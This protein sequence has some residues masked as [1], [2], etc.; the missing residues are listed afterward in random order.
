MGKEG[1]DQFC[2]NLPLF[3]IV[4]VSRPQMVLGIWAHVSN[5]GVVYIKGQCLFWVKCVG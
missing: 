1:W 5:L 2:I 3:D 4:N